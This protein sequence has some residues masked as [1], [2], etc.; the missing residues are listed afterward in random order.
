[1]ANKIL[2]VKLC[3]LDRK[4]GELHGRIEQSETVPHERLR[5]EIQHLRIS[6]KSNDQMLRNNLKFSRAQAVQKLSEAYSEIVQIVRETK[7]SMKYPDWDSFQRETSAEEKILLAE[8]ALDFAMQAADHALL[9]SLEAID[10][11]MTQQELEAS[12][13]GKN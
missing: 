3:E 2:A 11:Q 12:D 5:Q 9:I 8:Y 13:P 10:A 4:V 6:C 1:M 7:N